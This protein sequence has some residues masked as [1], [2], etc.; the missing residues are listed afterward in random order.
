MLNMV[1]IELKL[2]AYRTVWTLRSSLL[3]QIFLKL[4][5][6]KANIFFTLILINIK[7]H[8]D[9]VLIKMVIFWM[10]KLKENATLAAIVAK[11]RFWSILLYLVS[12]ERESFS[13]SNET[14]C[15]K[16]YQV[17]RLLRAKQLDAVSRLT[18]NFQMV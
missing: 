7:N 10:P 9:K 2:G 16:I 15:N 17:L 13:H 14:K 3:V 8:N 5:R 6:K 18:L 11:S 12:I 4:V 1:E